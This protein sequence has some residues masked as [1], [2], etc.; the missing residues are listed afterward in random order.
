MEN[1]ELRKFNLSKAQKYLDKLKTMVI[2]PAPTSIRR[3]RRAYDYTNSENKYYIGV[4]EIN[5]LVSSEQELINNYN[6]MVKESVDSVESKLIMM[7]DY[8]NFKNCVYT[9]NAKSG[10]SDVLTQIDLLQE[11]KNIWG[12]IKS[13]MESQTYL[14][15]NK[16]GELYSKLTADYTRYSSNELTE[17]K[18]RIYNLDELK[19]KLRKINVELEELETKR[20]QLNASIVIEFNFHQKTLNLLGI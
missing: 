17:L 18:L 5:N 12:Q 20:D 11:E 4:N 1:R 9:L 3:G 2:T 8:K 6:Q 7:K 19:E 15:E 16:L 10:L 13:S 14:P